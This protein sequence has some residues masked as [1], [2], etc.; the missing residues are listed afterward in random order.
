M[1]KEIKPI[2]TVYNG[3][4]FRSRLEARWAVFFDAAGIRYEYEPEGF[5][6]ENGLCYLPDFYLPDEDMYVEVKAP[7]YD[8]WK[9]L[10]KALRFVGDKI[11]CLMVLTN[12]PS[13]ET[14][15]V[16]FPI[17]YYNP[18]ND[19]L[20][21]RHCPFVYG[22][23]GPFVTLDRRCPE[24]KPDEDVSLWL[25]DWDYACESNS[26]IENE[27]YELATETWGDTDRNNLMDYYY[28]FSSKKYAPF[29]CN[30]FKK[31]RQ[32]R[33]EHGAKG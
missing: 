19:D 28:G 10:Y 22:M 18:V 29:I 15:I 4:K 16:L 12:I 2:E 7:R 31:A 26:D 32:A 9:D 6:T 23:D 3:Y 20:M 8:Q 27:K 1:N 25:T 5:R 13:G 21:V 17:I 14:P 30:C 24:T 11:K 33:F